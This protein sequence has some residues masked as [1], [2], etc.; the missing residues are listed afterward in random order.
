MDLCLCPVAGM[1]LAVCLDTSEVA[2]GGQAAVAAG[3]VQEAVVVVP[4]VLAMAAAPGRAVRGAV[5]KASGAGVGASVALAMVALVVWASTA[6]AGVVEV[7]G[8]RPPTVLDW[9]CLAVVVAARKATLVRLVALVRQI[10]VAAVVVAATPP[11]AV[12]VALA[13]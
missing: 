8:I 10:V 6:M 12:L 2:T 7:V 5:V 3:Q 9:V 13:L 1:A 11:L 4:V